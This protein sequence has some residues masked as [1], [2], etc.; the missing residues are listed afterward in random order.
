MKGIG[1][2]Y[3]EVATVL[4]AMDGKI[5]Y[6]TYRFC[7][8][9]MFVIVWNTECVPSIYPHIP[10]NPWWTQRHDQCDRLLHLQKGV[11]VW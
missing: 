3:Y 8:E 9:L 4:G 5:L 11:P 10:V 1:E 7:V 6:V 2:V